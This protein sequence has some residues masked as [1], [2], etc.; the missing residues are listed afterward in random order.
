MMYH[1]KYPFV[2]SLLCVY[3]N[4][5]VLV[6]DMPATCTHSTLNTCKVVWTMW[7]IHLLLKNILNISTIEWSAYVINAQIKAFLIV[8]H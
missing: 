4:E 7:K 3:S 5:Q 1:T 2:L 6:V 8:T